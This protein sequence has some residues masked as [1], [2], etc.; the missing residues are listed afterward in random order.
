MET[1]PERFSGRRLHV[2]NPTVT[3][4]RTT[5][6]E[7]AA[8]GRRIAEVLGRAA[9]PT[10]LL[11]PQRGISAL[12]A[13]GRP[14]HDPAADDALF[15]AIQEGL[16]GSSVRVVIRDEHINDA[17]FAETAARTLLELM[18]SSMA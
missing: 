12:D 11:L 1:V 15:D 17:G 6:Q 5:A 10:V 9:G 16:R 14:F 2:H 8:L 13:P 4:M 7:N 18:G 3:L